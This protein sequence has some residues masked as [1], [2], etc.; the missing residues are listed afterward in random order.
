MRTENHGAIG[1]YRG[2]VWAFALSLC[3]LLISPCSSLAAV[4]EA[5]DHPVTIVILGSSSPAGKNIYKL[6][7][8][9]KAEESVYAE[10]Y[11]WVTLYGEHLK[12]LNS[13]NKVINLAA[14]SGHS[15]SIA[16]NEKKGGPL[17]KNSLAYALDAYPHADAIIVNFP[18]IRG[19]EGE[20]VESVVENLKE[21]ERRALAAGARK[22]WIATAQ[23]YA[24][25]AECFKTKSGACDPSLTTHQSRIDLTNAIVVAFPGRYIDFYSPLAK[26][27][28]RTGVADPALLNRKDKL[29]P[30][31]KGHEA[32]K[33]AVI[34]AGIY[35]AALRD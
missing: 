14:A 19:Q 9:P 10:K 32:L 22:V 1:R 20:S 30:N 17:H 13:E 16:L 35:E 25:K 3:A 4:A 7:D 8:R 2:S 23:P 31:L 29:H 26:G 11:N 24:N 34:A 28:N 12:T 15:T 27:G 6:F 5:V 18:A 21:I 33:D